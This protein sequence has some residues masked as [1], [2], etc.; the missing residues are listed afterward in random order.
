M[1]AP[2][3][4]SVFAEKTWLSDTLLGAESIFLGCAHGQGEG[5]LQLTGAHWLIFPALA[6]P[7]GPFPGGSLGGRTEAVLRTL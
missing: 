5:P 1:W 7:A 2:N 3:L 6:C 4:I